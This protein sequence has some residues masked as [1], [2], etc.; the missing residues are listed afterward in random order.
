M[1]STEM[2]PPFDELPSRLIGLSSPQRRAHPFQA[3]RVFPVAATPTRA[4]L[5]STSLGAHQVF[6]NGAPVDDYLLKPGWTAYKHRVIGIETD[7]TALVAAGDNVIV[8]EV[9]GGWFTEDFGHRGNKGHWYG[10]QPSVA[11]LLEIELA[12]G[13]V[14]RLASDTSWKV[15]SDIALR[16]SSI[17]DG[18]TFDGRRRDAT[19]HSVDFDDT[20]WEFASAA[21]A[22]PALACVPQTAAPVRVTEVIEPLQIWP[23]DG[24]HYVVDFGQNLVGRIRLRVTGTSGDAVTLRH[25]EVLENGELA[26]RPLRAAAAT[27][28]YILRGGEPEEWAPTFTF[29]GFRF[30]EISGWPGESLAAGDI[31]AEVIGTDLVRTGHFAS[32]SPL[33]NRFHENVVWSARGNFLSIPTDCP[34]R[35]ERLGWTGDVQV[36]APAASSIF[37]V[38]AFLR[39]WLADLRLEQ[40]D[41]G[42]VVPTIAPDPLDDIRSPVAG[43]GDAA[44]TVPWSLYERYGDLQVLR[45][46]ISSMRD[47]VRVVRARMKDGVWQ[48]DFQFGDWLDPAAPPDQPGFPVTHHDLIATAYAFRSATILAQAE[49][50]LGKDGEATAAAHWADEVRTGFLETFV[51]TRGLLVSDSVGAYVTAIGL[52]LA[53]EDAALASAWGDRLHRLV[54][55]SGYR[56]STG[57][58]TTP[59]LCDALV[60]S[61]Y[62]DA[63]LRV[64]LQEQS[65]SWLAPVLLDATTV[66]ERWDSMLPDGTV[67]PG[68]MTSFNHYAL[69]AVVDFVHR[70]VAG[71]APREPGYAAVTF[72][73]LPPR[74]LTSASST[75]V[76][77]HGVASI[78]W[79]VAA[80]VMSVE[81]EVAPGT[82]AI[83][84]DPYTGDEMALTPG[85]HR[86]QVSMPEPRP[87]VHQAVGLRMP[88]SDV[89]DDEAIYRAILGALSEYS[90]SA[91]AEFSGS[92][93]WVPE[94]TLR[95]ALLLVPEAVRAAVESALEMWPRERDQ[96]ER[97]V[98]AQ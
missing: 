60:D 87:R 29:H 81:M 78:S 50:L 75:M 73:P 32:S 5:F 2:T 45:D 61:G 53:G 52:G 39:S 62:P 7:V 21:S 49:E 97:E 51:T 47:W 90:P 64:L 63:A 84:V 13:T 86:V 9:A 85:R 58:L 8:A 48:G 18:E 92:G 59:L 79:T 10:E 55:K 93:V 70:R 98:V 83:F 26:T 1:H 77:P 38:D 17:Y 57:F 54:R 41:R 16:T 24:G 65:P 3:R 69:G 23:R 40:D 4:V 35:D 43:W 46:A 95:S 27:D 19:I 72:A 28:R 56:I 66:W 88:L 74:G 6:I 34:Q 42:G 25:A 82:S 11:M 94:R 22:P 91:A 12:D 15:T 89:I 96:H 80:G 36:F 31:Q 37:D 20:S 30:A 14:L 76:T 68:E 44:T 71:I 33:L 67:N